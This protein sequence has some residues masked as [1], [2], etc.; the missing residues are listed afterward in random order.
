MSH[1]REEVSEKTRQ[2]LA[3]LGK[4]ERVLLQEVIQAEKE[5]IHMKTPHGIYDNLV[6]VVERV[7]Q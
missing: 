4:E 2:L 7:I 1:S 3:D 5:K 6:K